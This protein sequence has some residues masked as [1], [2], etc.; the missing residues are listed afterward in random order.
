V[1]DPVESVVLAGN[2]VDGLTVYGPFPDVAEA[3]EWADHESETAH[4]LLSGE[5]WVV[6]VLNTP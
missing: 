6:A 2:P 5:P 3:N 1:A 4:G